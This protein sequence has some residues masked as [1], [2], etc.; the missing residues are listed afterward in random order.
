MKIKVEDLMVGDEII[1]PSQANLKYIKVL[2]GP[3]LHPKHPVGYN[4]KKRYKSILCSIY[5]EQTIVPA[6]TWRKQGIRNS[7]KLEPNVSLHNAKIYLNLNYTD[8]WLVKRDV[9]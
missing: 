8:I 5:S 2:R 7:Y 4:G 6:T 3:V 9:I 1:V